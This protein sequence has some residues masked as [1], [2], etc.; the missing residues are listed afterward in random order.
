MLL[1]T[2]RSFLSL[3]IVILF[4]VNAFSNENIEFDINDKKQQCEIIGF[5]PETEKFADCVLRL[6]E[7]DVKKQ[8]QNQIVIAESSGNKELANQ[9]RR[10]NNIQSSQALINLGQQLMNPKRYNS[11]IYMPQTQRCII[12]GFGSFA[13]MRCR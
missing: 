8:T 10:Q 13:T 4:S 5:K 12:N 1:N 6:V 3:F 11:N 9:L 7:L 2:Y